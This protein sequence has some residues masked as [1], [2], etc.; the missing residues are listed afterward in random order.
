MTFKPLDRSQKQLLEQATFQFEGDLPGSPAER[1][2]EGRGI[3]PELS[4]KYRLGYVG[5]VLDGFEHFSGRIAFPSISANGVVSLRFKSMD[6]HANAKVLG[7]TGWPTRLFN[8]RAIKEAGDVIG[9][10]EGEPDA[11]SVE[12]MGLPAVGVPGSNA[13]ESTDYRH[14]GR[15]FAGFRKVLIFGDGDKA[16]REFAGKVYESMSVDVEAIIVPMPANEDCNSLFVN[17]RDRLKAMI[18]EYSR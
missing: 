3:S 2:L 1:Y 17:D 8:A 7:M 12:A 5:S 18:T 16:G 6:P 15:L 14:H 4:A 11:I 9:I 10:T 13:W